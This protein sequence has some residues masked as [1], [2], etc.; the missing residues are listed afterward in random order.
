[1]TDEQIAAPDSSAVRVALWRAL[2]VRVDSLPHVLE[3]EIGLQL[4][5]PEDGWRQRSDMNPQF[6]SPFRASIV[7]RA[8]FIEDLVVEQAARG[9]GQYVILEGGLDTFAQ[10]RP[11]VASNLRVFEG[12][13]TGPQSWKRQR[14][15]ETRLRNPGLAEARACRLRGRCLLVGATHISGSRRRAASGRSFRRRQYVSHQGH[16]RDHLAPDYGPRPRIDTRHD[17][18]VAARTL[19]S[20]CSFRTSVCGKGSACKRDAVHQL[21]HAGGDSGAGARS[22]L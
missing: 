14:L 15:I 3:D 16:D 4:V 11:E 20:R 2:H 22:R 6:T 9:I 17:I 5:A 10:R 8:R 21:L 1:M 7:A 13:R 19:G 18:P 12:D